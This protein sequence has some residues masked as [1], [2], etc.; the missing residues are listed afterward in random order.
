MSGAVEGVVHEAFEGHSEKPYHPMGNTIPDAM[1]R[2]VLSSVRV[3][4]ITLL[5]RHSVLG[6]SGFLSC[7]P[8]IGFRA[9][10]EDVEVCFVTRASAEHLHD[11]HVGPNDSASG[12]ALRSRWLEP[13]GRGNTRRKSTDTW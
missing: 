6:A 10:S 1:D 3:P 9:R 13:H 5:G 7:A 8:H 11:E 4:A 2:G 12:V